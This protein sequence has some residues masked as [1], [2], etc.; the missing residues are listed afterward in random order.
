M[1]LLLNTLVS[2]FASTQTDPSL[3]FMHIC[4]HWLASYIIIKV[5]L[6]IQVG[7]LASQFLKVSSI[8]WAQRLFRLFCRDYVLSWKPT[9]EGM[10]DL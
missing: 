6:N 10:N 7:S 4:A 9:H 2:V 8:F 1:Q 3:R 5:G